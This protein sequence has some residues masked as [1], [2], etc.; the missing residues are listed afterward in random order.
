MDQTTAWRLYVEAERRLDRCR[1]ASQPEPTG[2]RL[3]EYQVLSAFERWLAAAGLTSRA[4][5]VGACPAPASPI[6]RAAWI[7]S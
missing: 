1:L 7:A 3:A 6:A 2:T 5:R 4:T